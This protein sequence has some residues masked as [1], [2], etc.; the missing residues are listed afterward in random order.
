M[1]RSEIYTKLG[2]HAS[3]VILYLEAEPRDVFEM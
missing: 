1:D 3:E 2:A